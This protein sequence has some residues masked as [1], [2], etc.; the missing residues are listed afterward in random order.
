M[1]ISR[2]KHS[3]LGLRKKSNDKD[4]NEPFRRILVQ[5]TI[6][7]INYSLIPLSC[8]LHSVTMWPLLIHIINYFD[9]TLTFVT[10]DMRKCSIIVTGLWILIPDHLKYT[11]LYC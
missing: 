11:C 6:K 9:L 4:S 3:G 5:K 7:L 10:F 8:G 1:K 2:D